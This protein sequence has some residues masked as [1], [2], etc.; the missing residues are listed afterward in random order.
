MTVLNSL[1]GFWHKHAPGA[2]S[3]A[4]ARLAGG[5]PR[6]TDAKS[7]P[8][9]AV[10]ALPELLLAAHPLAQALLD[11][12][13]SRKRAGDGEEFWQFRPYQPLEPA[14]AID[15]RQSARSPNPE[16]LWV[17]EHEQKTPRTL[18]IWIDPSPSMRWEP[19]NATETRKGVP[20]KSE[21][22]LTAALA[23]GEAALKAGE[24]VGVAGRP[25]LYMGPQAFGALAAAL[26]ESLAEDRPP[27]PP[28]ATVPPHAQLLLVSDFLW[29]EKS[30]EEIF[31]A[32][33]SRPGRTAL[34]CVLDPAERELPY[35]GQVRFTTP[36]SDQ[37][38][39]LPA[40]ESLRENY[41]TELEG[42]LARLRSLQGPRS[43]FVLHWTDT[44]LLPPLM[45]LHAWLGKRNAAGDVRP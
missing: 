23:L 26:K 43:R 1:L 36:E 11:G 27:L 35:R 9:R 4:K 38:L 42:H 14:S 45:Q 39:T 32:C 20:T 33:T 29:P 30:M 12:P 31:S 15:W 22:A 5:R 40:V 24:R 34:L 17:R 7:G 28:L 19:D 6:P 8:T 2:G 18:L 3:H 41:R 16:I 13:H 37:T 25:R 44:S 21:A 10:R